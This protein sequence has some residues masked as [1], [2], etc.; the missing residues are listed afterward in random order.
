MHGTRRGGTVESVAVFADMVEVCQECNEKSRAQTLVSLSAS[1]TCRKRLPNLRLHFIN[2]LTARLAVLSTE[3]RVRPRNVGDAS[4][5]KCRP[6]H[7]Y[8]VGGPRA[9]A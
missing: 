5:V 9:A 6:E 7:D 1:A 8:R 4:G 3:L 2:D